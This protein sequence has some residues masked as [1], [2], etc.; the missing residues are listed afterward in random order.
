MKRIGLFIFILLLCACTSS[1]KTK[2]KK[3]DSL[4]EKLRAVEES[5]DPI[6]I[7]IEVEVEKLEDN[8]NNYRVLINKSDFDM[9]DITALAITNEEN[10]TYPS[11][12]I[13]DD[14]VTISK[15]STEKGIKLSGYFT[16]ED[17]MFRVYVSFKKDG[18]T[19][20]YYYIVDKVTYFD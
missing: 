7:D 1:E 6:D 13:F 17:V 3:Y 18:K 15:D 5:T 10:T 19:K 12:G 8:T 11:I 9:V 20:E 4:V 2:L 14:K 16:R